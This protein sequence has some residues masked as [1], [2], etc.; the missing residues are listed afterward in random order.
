M[1]DLTPECEPRRA[2][3]LIEFLRREIGVDHRLHAPARRVG[4]PEPLA[5]ALADAA[6]QRTESG[7]EQTVLV[8]EVVRNQ[9]GGDTG[10]LR[11]LRQRAA[12]VSDLRQAI[13]RDLDELLA[14]CLLRQLASRRAIRARIVPARA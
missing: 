13:D 2:G 7:F 12:H 3:A 5:H 10:P 1:Q 11:D 4:A 9:S 6:R 14:A 8:T